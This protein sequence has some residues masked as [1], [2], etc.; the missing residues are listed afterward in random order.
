MKIILKLVEFLQVKG[1]EKNYLGHIGRSTSFITV[2]K[3]IMKLVDFFTSCGQ[4]E[5]SFRA[6]RK[7]LKLCNCIQ[8]YSEACRIFSKVMGSYIDIKDTKKGLQ[9]L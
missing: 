5:K 4:S 2:F 9:A 3:I 1:S 6:L 7:V 8:K